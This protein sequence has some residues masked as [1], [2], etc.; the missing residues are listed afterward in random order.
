MSS[1]SG[2][3]GGL[4]SSQ[5]TLRGLSFH[6]DLPYTTDEIKGHLVDIIVS[7]EAIAPLPVVVYF[8]RG[9]MAR[10]ARAAAVDMCQMFAKRGYAVIN[11]DVRAI[12][13]KTRFEDILDDINRLLC[14][15][16]TVAEEYGLDM[17]RVYAAGT[18]RGSPP[19]LWAALICNG[20]RIRELMDVK[21]FPD[22][23]IRGLGLFSP[24]YMGTELDHKLV[25]ALKTLYRQNPE[26]LQA[27]IP[28][29]NHNLEVLPPVFISASDRELTASPAE[30]LRRLLSKNR[31]DCELMMF[32]NAYLSRGFA[33]KAPM[34]AESIRS[35]SRMLMF[36][37]SRQ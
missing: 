14:W 12:D 20:N 17:N 33:E 5:T 7:K 18:F 35:V 21:A 29:R 31:V 26:L 32:E 19:A 11:A 8:N 36:L 27:A 30:R 13:S 28:A 16:P 3:I 4:K 2:I 34:S 15:I 6:M 24:V 9:T 10:H 37:D 22:Y 1:A 25:K 23:E